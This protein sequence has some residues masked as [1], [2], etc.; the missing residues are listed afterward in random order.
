M[1]ILSKQR[2]ILYSLACHKLWISFFGH[3]VYHKELYRSMSC[4]NVMS[5]VENP[6]HIRTIHSNYNLSHFIFIFSYERKIS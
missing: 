4:N 1:K 6:V 2:N 3:D 5:Y